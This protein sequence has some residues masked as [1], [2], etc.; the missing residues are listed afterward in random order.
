MNTAS[1]APVELLTSP[2]ST[3]FFDLVR[4]ATSELLIASPFLSNAPLSKV[5]EIAKQKPSTYFHVHL[6]TNLAV[7]SLLS[8]SLDIAALLKLAQSLPDSAVTYLPSL[9]A[10]IYVA[11]NKAAIVTSGNLTSNGLS[12]NREYGVLLRDSTL[13]S[14]VRSDLLQYAALGNKVSIDALTAINQA[15][16]ELKVVRQQ[17]DNSINAKLR[18]AFKQRTESAH[19]ELL[20][21][22]AQGKSTHRLFCDTILYV[23]E[24]KGPLKTVDLHPLVQQIHPDFC[25]DNIDVVIDNVHFGKKW[26]HHV[27]GAQVSLRRQGLI[28]F[29]G[30]RWRRI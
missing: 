4:L 28:D 16:Q 14:K 17:A 30:A 2:W 20:K 23:L 7:D 24:Q 1:V 12:A 21:A 18:A 8:G 13:V 10:K 19:F 9:H 3:V 11:D 29:D 25:D 15:A 5:V 6:V 26:K 22:R 27:R